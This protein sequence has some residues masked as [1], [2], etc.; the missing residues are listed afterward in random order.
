MLKQCIQK[1]D[2]S[3]LQPSDH[4][5]LSGSPRLPIYIQESAF[6]MTY[7]AIK[8]HAAPF[9]DD[10]RGFLYFHSPAAEIRFRITDSNCPSSFESGSDL[11]YPYPNAAVWAISLGSLNAHYRGY[12]ALRDLL[13]RGGLDAHAVLEKMEGTK[14]KKSNSMPLIDPS[15][16]QRFCVDFQSTNFSPVFFSLGEQLSCDIVGLFHYNKRGR[17]NPYSGTQHGSSLHLFLLSIIYIRLGVV[18]LRNAF[19]SG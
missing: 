11:V 19:V 15:L 3:K 4:L 10:A 5:N 7:T 17:W 8:N 12:Q 1:L 6:A 2:P 14:T 18:P 13:V 9:P 16:A